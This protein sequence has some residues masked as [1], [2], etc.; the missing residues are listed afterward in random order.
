MCCTRI[1]S[2]LD[3]A[4]SY[5]THRLLQ[6]EREESSK[7]TQKWLSRK[8]GGRE[9]NELYTWRKE[10]SL[11]K[12]QMKDGKKEKEEER[13]SLK[14]H[15]LSSRKVY[16]AKKPLSDM[17]WSDLKMISAVGCIEII[18]LGTRRPK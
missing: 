10:E 12:C 13:L 1:N 17:T 9:K 2:T 3:A 7:V 5:W 8:E 18:G 15:L 6:S 14:C 11:Q 16:D 4:N